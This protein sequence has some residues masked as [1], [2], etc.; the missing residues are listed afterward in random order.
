MIQS[1]N[2]FHLTFKVRRRPRASAGVPPAQV[3]DFVTCVAPAAKAGA[4]RRCAN[5][6]LHAVLVHLAH[7]APASHHPT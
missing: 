2:R 4:A 5:Q 6:L 1:E 7:S 3:L